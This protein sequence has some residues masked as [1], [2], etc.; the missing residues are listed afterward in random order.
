MQNA[1]IVLT[2]KTL[3]K[4]KGVTISKLLSECHLTKSFIYDLEKRAVSPSCDKITRIADYFNVS[5]DYLL[6]RENGKSAP[7][8]TDSAPGSNIIFF[9]S[10][11]S[12]LITIKIAG[13]DGSY[14]EQ[15]FTTEQAE[16]IKLLISQTE[17][18]TN[19]RI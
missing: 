14:N 3:C 6:G 12:E 13:R 18:S 8:S 5:V 16:F 9:N 1:H 10:K 17:D 4:S 15:Q 19:P 11:S 2:I 7:P